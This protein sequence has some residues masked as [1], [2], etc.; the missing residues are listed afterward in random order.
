MQ[1][2]YMYSPFQ[3]NSSKSIILLCMVMKLFYFTQ[4]SKIKCLNWLCSV[5]K[6]ETVRHLTEMGLPM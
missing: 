4:I 3:D 1:L 5:S 2:L 6:A